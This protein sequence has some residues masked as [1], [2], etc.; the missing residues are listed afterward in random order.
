MANA[1]A[2]SRTGIQTAQL[3]SPHFMVVFHTRTVGMARCL[4]KSTDRGDRNLTQNGIIVR[5][6]PIS[7]DVNPL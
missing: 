2:E 5:C 3:V 1:D 7:Q 6:S 4:F